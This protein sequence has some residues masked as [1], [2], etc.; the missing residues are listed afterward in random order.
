MIVDD[1]SRFTWNMFLRTKDKTFDVL[2]TF[3][4]AIQLKI[5]CKITSSRSDHC[6]EFEN[7]QV[8]GFCTTM[9]FITISLLP[10]LLKKMGLWNE[11][12]KPW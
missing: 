1:F 9:G 2:S 4:K 10:E 12:T 3:S 6:I 5:N 8:E 7:A 11:R